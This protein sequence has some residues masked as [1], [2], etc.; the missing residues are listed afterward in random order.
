MKLL[1]KSTNCFRVYYENV[2]EFSISV[3]NWQSNFK[4]QKLRKIWKALDIDIISIIE[5][6]LNPL[7]LDHNY[8]IP[9]TLFCNEVSIACLSNN[10]IELIEQRQQYS[11]LTAVRGELSRMAYSSESDYSSLG[12]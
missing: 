6:Q 4:Y 2:N 3:Y 11:I 8:N 5:T 7:L 10:R 1:F 12:R 9:S